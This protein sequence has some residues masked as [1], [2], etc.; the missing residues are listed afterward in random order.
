MRAATDGLLSSS[1]GVGGRKVIGQMLISDGTAMRGRR[2]ASG[3]A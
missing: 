2:R 3:R 1:D